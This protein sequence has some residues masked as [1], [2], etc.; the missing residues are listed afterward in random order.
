MS[1]A[2]RAKKIASAQRARWAK[3]N[4]AIAETMVEIKTEPTPEQAAAAKPAKK[5]EMSGAG[6]T[7]II[8]AKKARWAKKHLGRSNT[9]DLGGWLSEGV[10]GT[11]AG[12]PP[13]TDAENGADAAL[14]SGL[15]DEQV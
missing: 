4:A 6:R 8:A 9:A 5:R 13:G 12:Q 1:A 3:V 15:A 11:G 2:G 7:A 14:P 10:D